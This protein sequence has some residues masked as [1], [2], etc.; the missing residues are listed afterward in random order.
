[1]RRSRAAPRLKSR[2]RLHDTEVTNGARLTLPTVRGYQRLI[3]TN[4]MNTGSGP[5]TQPDGIEPHLNPFGDG[6]RPARIANH[7]AGRARNAGLARGC[8]SRRRYRQSATLQVGLS[9]L[10]TV[11]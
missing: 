3:A 2:L 8:V 11:A 1:M 6:D 7:E 9:S 4:G 5:D 10:G